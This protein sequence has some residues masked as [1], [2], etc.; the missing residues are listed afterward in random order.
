MSGITVHTRL[1]RSTLLGWKTAQALGKQGI[2]DLYYN[3]KAVKDDQTT[4]LWYEAPA[5]DHNQVWDVK[6]DIQARESDALGNSKES[7]KVVASGE[8]VGAI[9]T[10]APD[11]TAA[12]AGAIDSVDVTQ[13]RMGAEQ[14]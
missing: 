13:D 11:N 10:V 7:W 8:H 4:I 5:N 12:V 2:S 9:V 3:A 14:W 1:G 6:V